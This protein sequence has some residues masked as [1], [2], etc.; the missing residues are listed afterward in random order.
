[1]AARAVVLCRMGETTA[2]QSVLRRLESETP[3]SPLLGW[4]EDACDP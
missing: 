3:S 1:M 2:G 4:A